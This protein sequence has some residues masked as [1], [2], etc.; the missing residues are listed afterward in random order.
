MIEPRWSKIWRDLLAH[1]IR[2]LLTVLSI[3]IGVFAILVVIGGRGMLVESFDANFPRSV[4]PNA[5]LFTTDFGDDLVRT[6]RREPGVRAADGRRSTLLRF[7]VGDHGDTPEPPAGVTMADR[8]RTIEIVSAS[9]WAAATVAK[10]FAADGVSWPPGPGEVVIERSATQEVEVAQGDSITVDTGDG[11]LR[12]LRVAGFAH[13]INAFPAMF[14]GRLRGF[15][16]MEQMERLRQPKAYNQLVVSMDRTDLTRDEAS[17]FAAHLRDD[18]LAPRGVRVY[19]MNVPKPNSHFLGDIFRAVA[20]LLLALGIMALLLS[21]FLVVNTVSALVAQQVR[22]VGV[23]KAIGARSSQIMWMYLALV[24]AYGLLAVL[25]GLPTGGWWAGW[26]ARFGGGLLNFGDAPGAPPGYALA[27]AIAVGLLVP[28]AA[29]FVPVRTGTRISVVN[30]FNRT[31]MSSTMFGHGLIDRVLGLVRGLPRPVALGLRNTFLRKGRL[32]MTL[33]TL[34]LASTVVMS[35]MSVRASMLKT[36][37]DVASWWRYDVEVSYQQPVNRSAVE[38]EILSTPGVVAAESWILHGAAM[39]R[40]DGSENDAPAVDGLPPASTFITPRLV[41][42]RWIE[43]GD[44]GKV[45]VNTDIANDE[46]LGIGDTRTFTVRGKELDWQVVGI[47]QGQLMGPL[48]FAD[49]DQLG[50]VLGEE[51]AV[52]RTVVRTTDHSEAGQRLAAD[53]LEARLKAA[54]YLVS[55]VRTQSGMSTTLAN[56]LGILVTFLIVMAVILA[57]VGVIGLSGTMIINVLE[58]TREIGVMRAVGASHRSIFQV[59]VTEGVVIGVLSWLLGAAF[60]YP[61][62]LGL[63]RLLEKAIT[64]P[65]SYEFSWGG[66]GLWLVIVAAISAVASLLPAFR[67]SQVSVRDAIAYE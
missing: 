39:K 7:R 18:V 51:N 9:D 33:V 54:G 13:D 21:G 56:E 63:V 17:R 43:P 40:P 62:S 16:S 19:G 22:Q 46:G 12:V 30:A 41:E 1:K 5:T 27:L 6:V 20:V 23:M 37:D 61:V 4:P 25:V 59:F 31:G 47:V 45:V 8:S 52:G 55:G 14:S 26:F 11:E 2:T 34:T 67:A 15:V 49:R 58:S 24:A 35:V 48:V 60:T 38:R 65:L 44:V 28:V 36:V 66:V 3:G 57:A 29:A 64:I 53:R 50:R 42:G 10:A 32:A